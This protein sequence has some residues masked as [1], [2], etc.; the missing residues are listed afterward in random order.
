MVT[1]INIF[2]TA[3]AIYLILGVV[4]SIYFYLNGAAKI[5]EGTQGTPWHFKLIIFPGVV[6]LWAAL[7]MKLIRKQ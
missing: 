2:L 1:I 4:F 7:L 6:L 3:L 5:D